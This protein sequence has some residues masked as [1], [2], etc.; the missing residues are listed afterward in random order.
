M[1]VWLTAVVE[2]EIGWWRTG[3]KETAI[4]STTSS[5]VMTL[6]ATL[7]GELTNYLDGRVDTASI[8]A[9]VPGNAWRY[10]RWQRPWPALGVEARRGVVGSYMTLL[11]G[12]VVWHWAL[13][14]R[15]V[16]L[17]RRSTGFT[18]ILLVLMAAGQRQQQG[19]HRE[20]RGISGSPEAVGVLLLAALGSRQ[21]RAHVTALDKVEERRDAASSGW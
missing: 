4:T 6:D 12:T 8:L 15:V 21:R 11:H 17:R 2:A 7:G 1:A 16:V 14:S 9:H 10:T 5:R 3:L 19:T 18:V 20:G 13:V